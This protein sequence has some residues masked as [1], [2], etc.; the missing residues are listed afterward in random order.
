MLQLKEIKKDY[1]AGDTIVP[2][3]KGITLNFRKNEFVAILGPSGCGKTTLLNIIGGL[4]RYTTGDLFI[5]S[6]STKLYKDKDWDTYRNHEIGFVFQS[7]NLIPHLTVL[8]NVELAL[9]LSGMAKSERRKLAKEALQRVG[10]E[11]QINKNPNQLSGG[12]MQRVAIARAIVNHPHII[13]ADEPTGALDTETSVQVMEILKE[14]SEDCLVIMVTH[15][16]SLADQYATRIVRLLDGEMISDSDPYQPTEEELLLDQENSVQTNEIHFEQ[17]EIEGKIVEETDSDQNVNHSKKKPIKK[18]DSK[19]SFFTA[20]TLSFKNLLTKKGRTFLISFAGSIGIIGISLVLSI[21]NGF[22]RYIDKLQNDMLSGYPV[23]VSRFAADYDAIENIGMGMKPDEGKFPDEE[24]LYIY[25]PTGAMSKA[26]HLNLIDQAYVDYIQAFYEEDLQR[27]EEER[28]TN[29]IQYSYASGSMNIM[30]H[31]K[32]NY[33]FVSQSTSSTGGSMTEM[34]AMF[35]GSSTNV[36][37]EALDN[38][39][40]IKRQYDVISGH[41]PQ[42]QNEVAIV[43]DQKNR[44][45]VSTLDALGISYKDEN[46]QNLPSIAFDDLLYQDENHPGVEFKVIR[47]QDYYSYQE[48]PVTDAS[49]ETTSTTPYPYFLPAKYDE[50]IKNS[51]SSYYQSITY[52]EGLDMTLRIVG[53]LRLSEDAPLDLFNSG[54]LYHPDLT[55]TF[56]ADAKASPIAAMQDQDSVFMYG[57][58]RDIYNSL[59]ALQQM[60]TNMGGNEYKLPISI[61][62]IVFSQYVNSEGYDNDALLTRYIV[63]SAKQTIGSSDVPSSIYIYPKSFAAKEKINAYLDSWN[64][65]QAHQN[66]K[67]IYTDAASVFSTTLGQMVDIISYVLIAFTAISLVVSSIMIGIITYV[68]VIE[69]TKEIGVLRSLGAR[70]RDISSVFNA[71]TL[72]IGLIAGLLGVIVTYV[73]CIP[74]NVL[75]RHLAGPTLMMNLAIFDPFHAL[76]LLCVSMALTIISGLIPSRIAANKD[77][78]IALRTE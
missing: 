64:L 9:T 2:A 13:L 43:V 70:K 68:S 78:V 58:Y 35:M 16:P 67:I 17:K 40:F 3:L 21:S 6:V 45:S 39:D 30:T 32:D 66:Q 41:Y 27:S 12:Q 52:P 60:V 37:Q 73:L 23:T 71:E 38:E 26:V 42:N 55:Q 18:K 44:M 14:I 74:I 33:S 75:I 4:D 25:D 15:N 57:D 72:L 65:D 62:K 7:Y 51:L 49:E 61:M 53:V 76:I 59:G 54:I 46:G 8:G 24:N 29:S 34:M 47:N 77:P 11:D 36:F 28:L 31:Y 69:R 63:E 56:I 48:K 20:L 5:N 10:L 19:M 22:S 50:N 1:K